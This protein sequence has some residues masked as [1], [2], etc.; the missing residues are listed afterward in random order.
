MH[1]KKKK[2]KFVKVIL[3]ISHK[4]PQRLYAWHLALGTL[5]LQVD[6]IVQVRIL[7]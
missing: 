6:D 2:L 4:D 1:V 5:R 7:N 3:F